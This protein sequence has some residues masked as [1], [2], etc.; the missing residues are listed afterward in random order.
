MDKI[1]FVVLWV[2][3]NDPQWRKERQKYLPM[4]INSG[5]A[6]NRF[7][8][9]DLM[10]YWFRGVE[11]FAPWVNN[12]YF[13]TWGHHPEWLNFNHPKL[14]VVNHKDYIPAE[15]LPTFNS[16]VIELNLH[17]LTE[18]SETF[19][20][21]NDDMWLTDYVEK[22]DFFKEGK[23][24]DTVRLGQTFAISLED[25]GPYA[26][27]NNMALLN[28]YFQKKSVIRQ[29]WRSIFSLK[30]GVELIRNIL[31]LPFGHFSGFYDTHLCSSH[32]KSTF[33]EI[34]TKEPL[35]LDRCSRNRFREI[36]DLTH[37]LMKNWYFCKGEVVPRSYKWGGYFSIGEDEEL[38]PAIR[39]QKYKVICANDCDPNM[40]FEKWQAE[41][42]AAF[43]TILPDKC[44][45][46]AF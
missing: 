32:L 23:P 26:V 40:D 27:F 43:E 29:N 21:F 2:D 9:W 11:K 34:W 36:T 22:S 37:G 19:V 28:K 12:V 13:V 46:E 42:V 8:D 15:Y 45:F 35:A 14:R 20:L 41:L 33:A 24:L 1:D 25:V 31:L 10:R 6:E 3:G 39:K 18:L 5:N 30:Y 16:N 17:R 4:E 38:I 44:S 7:R